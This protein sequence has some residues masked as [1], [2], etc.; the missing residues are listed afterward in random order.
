MRHP[1][2]GHLVYE[3]N[4][5]VH[6]MD[7]KRLEVTDETAW[8]HV[9]GDGPCKKEALGLLYHQGKPEVV[10][11]LDRIMKEVDLMSGTRTETVQD[12]E[13]MERTELWKFGQLLAS[14]KME[15]QLEQGLAKGREEGRLAATRRA[16]LL[17]ALGRFGGY[18]DDLAGILDQIDD[19]E[20]LEALIRATPTVESL[21]VL[22]S[23]AGQIVA[24]PPLTR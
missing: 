24:G 14:V 17:C 12:P 21:E 16:V 18:D 1:Q 8:L 3:D 11:I 22:R 9:A 23:R 6:W 19:I 4:P 13:A 15:V 10:G 5:P 7:L 2:R 20:Q